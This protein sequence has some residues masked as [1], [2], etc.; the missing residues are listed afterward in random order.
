MFTPGV[1]RECT[2]PTDCKWFL[3]FGGVPLHD[4]SH[5]EAIGVA[6]ATSPWGPFERWGGNPVF[7]RTDPGTLWCADNSAAR[8]DEIKASVVGGVKY[9]AV[10]CTCANF[11]ALPILYSPVNQSSWGP[12]YEPAQSP[13][14]SPMFRAT[15]TCGQHGFE[16]PTLY[17]AADSFLHFLGHNHGACT[18]EADERRSGSVYAHFI[19]RTG[20]IDSWD[21]APVFTLNGMEPVP[22]PAAGDGVFGLEILPTWI[23]FVGW[24][25]V[26]STVEMVWSN[27]TQG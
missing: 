27:A 19:S 12:P 26:A 9:F 24:E 16:E 25:L 7:T 14:V 10:K 3:F 11:T 20:A 22:V 1:V 17:T 13:A 21:R 23:D 8:V 2:T 15:E 5:T 4:T 6:I 18:T